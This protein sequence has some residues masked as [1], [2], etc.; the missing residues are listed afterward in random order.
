MVKDKKYLFAVIGLVAAI[1]IFGMG[2]VLSK[3]K[4]KELISTINKLYFAYSSYIVDLGHSPQSINDLIKNQNNIA[5]W[6]GPYISP[7]ILK[8]YTKGEITLVQ[9]SSIPTK[10]CSFDYLTYCYNWLKVSNLTS[11]DFNKIKETINPKSKIF[12]AENNL[13]FQLSSVE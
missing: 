11:A 7:T 1:I 6:N 5:R 3:T 10:N 4:S 9:A 8:S 2:F 13:F 12:F